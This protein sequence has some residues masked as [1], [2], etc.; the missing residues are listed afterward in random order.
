[1]LVDNIIKTFP[2]I[3][4][5]KLGYIISNHLADD[6]VRSCGME[7]LENEI[8]VVPPTTDIIAISNEGRG[9]NL[10]G[11]KEMSFYG[12]G[13]SKYRAF[14]IRTPED[15]WNVEYLHKYVGCLFTDNEFTVGD[16][17]TETIP[18][19]LD[20]HH[21]DKNIYN[22][23]YTNLFP[24]IPFIHTY[25][26]SC[27]DFQI[28]VENRIIPVTLWDFPDYGISITDIVHAIY[29]QYDRDLVRENYMEYDIQGYKVFIR[30]NKKVAKAIKIGFPMY[31]DGMR[32]YYQKSGYSSVDSLKD[33]DPA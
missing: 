4:K 25:L 33:G 13:A 31:L 20:C 21:I 17:K 32:N 2:R 23:R 6:E 27:E 28:E 5:Q 26:E 7:P 1:M 10:S 9:I 29:K 19:Y 12:A 24:V 18:F 15:K 8:F 11:K 16:F 30:H 22:N 14:T 3:K